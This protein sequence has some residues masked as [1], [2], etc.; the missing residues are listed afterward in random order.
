MTATGSRRIY[1]LIQKIE[2]GVETSELMSY[3]FLVF[4]LKV[5]V[6]CPTST[7]RMWN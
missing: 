5:N 1:L 7:I 3:D 6:K 4:K 2:N